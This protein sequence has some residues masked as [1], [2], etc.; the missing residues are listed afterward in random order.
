MNSSTDND[1]LWLCYNAEQS[2]NLELTILDARAKVT[3]EATEMAA[4]NEAFKDAMVE[5][6]NKVVDGVQKAWNKFKERGTITDKLK[7]RL[8]AAQ[9]Q[10]NSDFRMRLPVD[11]PFE[12][13]NLEQWDDINGKLTLQDMNQGTYNGM[14]Q[15]LETKD[16]F[17]KHYY[18]QFLV[19]NNDIKESIN[20]KVFPP[21]GSATVVTK[22]EATQFRDFL[23]TYPA[24]W[25]II[26]E[27]LK[28]VNN[29]AKNVETMLSTIMAT[30]AA[31][32]ESMYIGDRLSY[33]TE[34]DNPAGKFA[35]ADT[36]ETTAPKG[37]GGEGGAD[38]KYISN[39]FKAST[40]VIS[41]KLATCNKVRNQALKICLNYIKLQGGATA[42][43]AA[44]GETQT[45]SAQ[46]QG[47]T[48]GDRVGQVQV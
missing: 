15:Y 25:R 16:D 48:R 37:S 3:T 26:E 41:A 31:A 44:T 36:G 9:A 8:T 47:G 39:Y 23:F 40:A 12:Y 7:Q 35:N 5:Y 4:I 21:N 45:K 32:T 38:R 27:D 11:P 46:T 28:K 19:G 20:Q 6:I 14:K 13:P 34:D 43:A 10:F 2:L 33:L 30:P 42:K 29:S 18:Q 1:L 24:Q 17:I 22:A